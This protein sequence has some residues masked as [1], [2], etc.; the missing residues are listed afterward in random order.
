MHWWVG[1]S[2]FSYDEWK[3]CFYP[4]DLSAKDRLTYYASK[5]PA[6]EINNTFYRMPKASLL[7]GWAEQVPERFRFV[8]KA[9]QKITHF[10]RLKADAADETA[11]LLKTAAVLGARLGPILFQLP[12][13]MKKDVE[14]LDGFLAFLPEGTRAAFEFRHESWADEEVAA[15]LAARNLALCIADVDEEPEPDI[16]RTADWGYLR[17]R[18]TSYVEEDLARWRAKVEAAGWNDAYVFFKHEDEGT[19]PKLGMR[20]LEIAGVSGG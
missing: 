19:G 3:G 16:R 13:N 20:F 1:T 14:R 15:R 5:L 17:L 7:E 12:P 10:K 9:S 8:L 11:Y 6:V 2:G 4:E 18:R